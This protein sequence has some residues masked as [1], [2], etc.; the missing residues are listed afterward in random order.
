[1]TD[2]RLVNLVTAAAVNTVNK[3]KTLCKQCKVKVLI[4]ELFKQTNTGHNERRLKGA[5]IGL[6]VMLRATVLQ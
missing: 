5:V 4:N 6:L 3:I 1:M 2:S